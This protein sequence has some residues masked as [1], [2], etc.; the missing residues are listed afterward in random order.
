MDIIF[1]QIT[2]ERIEILGSSNST[3]SSESI[4]GKSENSSPSSDLIGKKRG[5]GR[6]KRSKPVDSNFKNQFKDLPKEA[7]WALIQAEFHRPVEERLTQS[8]IAQKYGVSRRT[9]GL[10]GRRL[11]TGPVAKSGWSKKRK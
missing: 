1:Q 11:S 10:W 4:G 6:P 3:P 2:A 8:D 9:V 5:R 7:I